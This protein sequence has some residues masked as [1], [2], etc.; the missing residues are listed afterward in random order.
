MSSGGRG[1]CPQGGSS[2]NRT[3]PNAGGPQ[4]L[5]AGAGDEPEAA[6]DLRTADQL[7]E[8][9]HQLRDIVNRVTPEDFRWQESHYERDSRHG[10]ELLFL[11]ANHEWVRATSEIV[12]VT[13][14]NAVD[15]TIKIDIDLGQITHGGIQQKNGAFVAASHRSATSSCGS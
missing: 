13:R 7:R 10:R 11:I 4:A 1:W 6:E 3:I 15:T 14:S 5:Q 12:N 2:M 9:A 8:Y